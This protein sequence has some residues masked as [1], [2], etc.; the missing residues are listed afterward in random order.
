MSFGAGRRLAFYEAYLL[1]A[2]FGFFAVLLPYLAVVMEFH[3]AWALS[4]SLVSALIWLYLRRSL[5]AVASRVVPWLL[6]GCLWIPTAA[7]ILQPHTG[8][9]YTLDILAGLTVLALVTSDARFRQGLA[10]ILAVTEISAA[11]MTPPVTGR[12]GGEDVR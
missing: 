12:E 3:L 10:D 1:A 7:V 8:L 6:L 4:A 11:P 9:I 5:G 2:C